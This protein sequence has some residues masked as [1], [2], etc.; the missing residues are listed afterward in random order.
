LL[1]GMLD[2]LPLA[3]AVGRGN[4]LGAFAT[5]VNGDVE[6]LPERDELDAFVKDQYDDVH[7]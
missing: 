3:E 1:S 4:A 7:R 5:M 6:G 2:G